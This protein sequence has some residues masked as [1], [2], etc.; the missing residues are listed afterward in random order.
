VLGAALSILLSLL[1]D[2]YSGPDEDPGFH[3]FVSQR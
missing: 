2:Y 1:S 3:I